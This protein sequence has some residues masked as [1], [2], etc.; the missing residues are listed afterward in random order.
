MKNFYDIIDSVMVSVVTIT[1][2]ILFLFRAVSVDGISMEPT[3]K[4]DERLIITNFFY[5][6]EKGD[7]VVVDKNNSYNKPLVKR[8]IATEGDTIKIDYSTGDVYVNNQ[9]I[10]ENYI[11]EKINP[12]S[13]PD[14]E[15]TVSEDCVFVMGDNRNH[16]ADSRVKEIGLIK[17]KNILGKAILRIYPFN[18]IGVL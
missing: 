18:N 1:F 7:I 16:S 11:N 2:I 13:I 8:V 4:H 12:E 6:P 15:V 9:L 14:L 10:V 5:N 17:N 3:L